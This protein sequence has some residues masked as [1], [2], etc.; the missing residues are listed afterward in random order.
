V[1]SDFEIFFNDVFVDGVII[2]SSI[3]FW[4]KTPRTS[5]GNSCTSKVVISDYEYGNGK[6]E[7]GHSILYN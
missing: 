1:F 5:C 4:I 6:V 2:L 3:S 7:V